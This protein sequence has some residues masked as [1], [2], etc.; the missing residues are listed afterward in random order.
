ML[1]SLL[2]HILIAFAHFVLSGGEGVATIERRG[3]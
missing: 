1:Q 3:S 2:D